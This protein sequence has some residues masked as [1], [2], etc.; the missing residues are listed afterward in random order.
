MG[1]APAYDRTREDPPIVLEVVAVCDAILHSP[2]LLP[3]LVVLIAIDGPFPVLPSETLLMSAASVAFGTHNALAVTGLFVA[4][5]I[6]S[7]AGDFLVFGLGR[8]SHR[9]LARAT[10]CEGGLSSW[11]RRHLLL[12]PG[13]VLVGARFVPG[14]RLVSTAAAGRFGLDVPRFLVGSVASSAAWSVYMLLIGLLLGPITGGS[15]L[16]S[17][18][19]GAVMAVL[20]AGLFALVQRVRAYRARRALAAAQH[21]TEPP[22]V[23]VAPR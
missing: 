14:G 10:E 3:V 6:G 22:L 12:R 4:A 1:L 18:L 17:L 2:W 11:V 13:T 20:T 7:V 9:V 8:S 15:P 21:P 16:L 23:L 19:A 5:L